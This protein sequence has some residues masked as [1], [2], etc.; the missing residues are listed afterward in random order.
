[1]ES[2]ISSARIWSSVDDDNAM[3]AI[4]HRDCSAGRRAHTA[5]ISLPEGQLEHKAAREVFSAV[6]YLYV[7]TATALDNEVKNLA[8]ASRYPAWL[9]ESVSCGH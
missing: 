4:P 9:E 3:L 7:R 5:R 8:V 2:P 6:Q 1:M